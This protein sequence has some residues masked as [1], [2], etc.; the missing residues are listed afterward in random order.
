MLVLLLILNIKSDFELF[1]GWAAESSW[2]GAQG[3]SIYLN[4]NL[5]H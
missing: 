2:R 1:L 3:D 5:F 4:S